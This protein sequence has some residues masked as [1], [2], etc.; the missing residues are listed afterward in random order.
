MR[1]VSA[2]A[3]GSPREEGAVS[4]AI[5]WGFVG[6]PGLGLVGVLGGYCAKEQHAGGIACGGS[7]GQ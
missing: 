1:G 3:V 7:H 4:L 5:A 6:V 2:R